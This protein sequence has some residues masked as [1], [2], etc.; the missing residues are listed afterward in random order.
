MTTPFAFITD[1]TS[2]K[3]RYKEID[4]NVEEYFDDRWFHCLV[5]KTSSRCGDSYNHLSIEEAKRTAE[6]RIDDWLKGKFQK[7][8]WTPEQI[9]NLRINMCQSYEDFAIILG[10][11]EFFA[12]SLEKREVLISIPSELLNRF[13]VLEKCVNHLLKN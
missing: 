8:F 4:Y 2:K 1:K 3:F 6:K 7:E 10:V 11:S 12:R 13:D 9:S 5:Y